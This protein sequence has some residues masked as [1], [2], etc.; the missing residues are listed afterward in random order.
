MENI[1]TIKKIRKAKGLTQKQLAEKIGVA[2]ITI[3]QYERGV[4]NPTI[5]TLNRIAM[6]LDVTIG[7][8]LSDKRL[9][10]YE[11]AEEPYRDEE[12]VRK[13]IEPSRFTPELV[14]KFFEEFGEIL[15]LSEESQKAAQS[16]IN[17][18]KE[19]EKDGDFDD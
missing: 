15:L 14:V 2:T 11:D 4:R 3:Q 12:L 19:Q 8:L 5:S 10:I 16:Y 13:L 1:V 17:Y 7:E 9:A 18:L 6:A